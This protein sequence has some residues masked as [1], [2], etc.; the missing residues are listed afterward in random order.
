MLTLTWAIR[1]TDENKIPAVKCASQSLSK[2]SSTAASSEH[3]ENGAWSPSLSPRPSY[4][5]L[6]HVISF[7]KPDLS[8]CRFLQLGLMSCV[9]SLKAGLTLHVLCEAWSTWPGTQR[10]LNQYPLI[11]TGCLSY[12]THK[13]T[14]GTLPLRIIPELCTDRRHQYCCRCRCSCTN[15]FCKV[16]SS[17]MTLSSLLNLASQNAHLSWKW[18]ERGLC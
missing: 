5:S 10:T 14:P 15:S 1:A 3:R 11:W 2:R 4:A 9:G 16:P 12:L 8:K 7:T 6:T 13:V 17:H 18:V